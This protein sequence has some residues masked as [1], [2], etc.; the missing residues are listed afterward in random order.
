MEGDAPELKRPK[1]EPTAKSSSPNDASVEPSSK[2]VKRKIAKRNNSK[3]LKPEPSSPS[4]SSSSSSLPKEADEKDATLTAPK[5]KESSLQMLDM[6]DLCL[7]EMLRRMDLRELCSMAEVNVRLKDFAQKVFATKHRTVSLSSLADPIDGKYTLSKVRQLLYN[8]GQHIK[9]LT[10][11]ESRLNDREQYGKLLLLVRKYV[12]ET[13]D[14]LVFLNQ[15][16]DHMGSM[17]TTMVFGQ[18]MFYRDVDLFANRH[19]SRNQITFQP[20]KIT[21][22]QLLLLDD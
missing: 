6:N 15:P 2:D 7:L 1:L 9:S 17:I 11:D 14:E 13:V 4:S 19:H 12:L 16:G 21:Q 10:I 8:F 18:E 22:E 5:V 20:R 3:E